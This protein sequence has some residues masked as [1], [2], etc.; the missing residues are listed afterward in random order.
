MTK[1]DEQKVLEILEDHLK[2]TSKDLS[3]YQRRHRQLDTSGKLDK[4]GKDNVKTLLEGELK[5]F[6]NNLMVFLKPFEEKIEE[7]IEEK[8][9]ESIEEIVEEQERVHVCHRDEIQKLQETV[10]EQAEKIEKLTDVIGCVHISLGDWVKH[11]QSTPKMPYNP[12]DDLE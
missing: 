12:F 4:R 7:S 11:F 6:E 10:R 5:K 8:I 1:R 9:E 2:Q 3:S